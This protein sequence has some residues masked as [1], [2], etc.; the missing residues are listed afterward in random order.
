MSTPPQHP[1]E[2]DHKPVQE[3]S[4][5]QA[6]P[7]PTSPEDK[8]S[9]TPSESSKAESHALRNV[10]LI[11]LGLLAAIAL[12]FLV[13]RGAQ[14]TGTGQVSATAESAATPQASPPAPSPAAS[15]SPSAA[16]SPSPTPKPTV[17]LDFQGTGIGTSD[18][19]DAPSQWKL[20]YNFECSGSEA[21]GMEIELYQDGTALKSLVNDA[22]ASG[23][24]TLL[25]NIGGSNVHL[26][27]HSQCTWRVKATT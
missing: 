20:T 25:I 7:A 14:E 8:A 15:A 16:R 9:G 17:L 2:P 11:A 10:A 19:F 18:P 5:A 24:A 6:P 23:D 13:G 3:P 26:V 27:I 12:G 1:E 21:A 4:E 22:S